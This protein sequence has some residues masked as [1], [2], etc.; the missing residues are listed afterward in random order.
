VIR[1]FEG[2]LPR[3]APS[4]FLAEG[5]VVIGDVEIGV[6][7]SVWY[8][9]VLR[10]DVGPIRV[11][12]ASNIQEGTILH[13]APDR[14]PTVLG[15]RVTVGH[16]AIL[17]GCSIGARSLI[18]MGATLLDGVVVGDEC[19]IGAGTL[20][21]PGMVVPPRTLVVGN[22]GKFSR[23]LGDEDVEWILAHSRH[24]VETKEQYLKEGGGQLIPPAARWDRT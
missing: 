15:S 21:P 23:R 22:P 6:D 19:I 10:G 4:A 18:G 2:T 16:G 1:P 5:V 17:H 13:C 8:G 11:G 9:C 24:Y 7:A 12:S 3:I 20:V 14:E